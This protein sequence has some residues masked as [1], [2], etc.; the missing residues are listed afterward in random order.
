MGESLCMPLRRDDDDDDEVEWCG[1]IGDGMG[2]AFIG[3]SEDKNGDGPNGDKRSVFDGIKRFRSSF[4]E[5][6]DG[7]CWDDG[8]GGGGGGNNNDG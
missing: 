1:G 2:G 4:K 6:G 3:K 7:W 5:N 8:S